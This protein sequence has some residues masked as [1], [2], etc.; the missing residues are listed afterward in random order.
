MCPFAFVIIVKIVILLFKQNK[1]DLQWLQSD[2]AKHISEDA[3][4]K[5]WN[6]FKRKYPFADLSKFEAQTDFID[7]KHATAEI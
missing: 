4:S 2:E 5:A 6:D 1:M 7:Q 3:K